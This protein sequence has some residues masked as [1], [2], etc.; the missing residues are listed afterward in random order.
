MTRSRQLAVALGQRLDGVGDLLFGEPAHLGDLAGEL[1]QIAVESLDGVVDHWSC[2]SSVLPRLP[3]AAGDVVL[4]ALI[5][6][7]W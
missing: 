6:A 5:V 2:V 7:A 4:R 3:E 1:L